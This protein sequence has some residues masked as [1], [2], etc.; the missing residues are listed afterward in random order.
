M[1]KEHLHPR[2]LVG[3]PETEAE[4]RSLEA[5]AQEAAYHESEAVDARFGATGHGPGARS[6]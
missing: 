1:L 3:A 6:R 4:R 2:S 5:Y